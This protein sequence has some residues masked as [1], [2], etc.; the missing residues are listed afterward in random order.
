[1][2]VEGLHRSREREKQEGRRD[3]NT[4]VK[5]DYVQKFSRFFT[6]LRQFVRYTTKIVVYSIQ[7]QF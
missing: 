6:R 7:R 3:E 5:V 2:Q 4:N 1:M